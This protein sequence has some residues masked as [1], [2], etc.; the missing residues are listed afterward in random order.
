MNQTKPYMLK[1]SFNNSKGE[2]QE[3]FME[4]TKA[5]KFAW[6]MERLGIKVHWTM[7]NDYIVVEA[8]PSIEQS[9]TDESI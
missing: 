9:S 3:Q 7:L 8:I 2:S 4:I 1:L 6:E 5:G